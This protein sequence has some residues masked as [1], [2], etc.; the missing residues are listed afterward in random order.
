M[1]LD[2]LA[3]ALRALAVQRYPS[4]ACALI[5]AGRIFPVQNAAEDATEEFVIPRMAWLEVEAQARAPV[6]AVFHSHPGG[7]DY[8]SEAD[9]RMQVASGV[10]WV[11]CTVTPGGTCAPFVWG[12][13]PPPLLARG[14]RHGVTDC[15]SLIRDWYRIERQVA[16]PEFPRAWEWWEAKDLYRDGFSE[17][18]FEL[19]E[20][21]P[22]VGDVFLARIRAPVPNHGGVYVG[23][24]LILHHPTQRGAAVDPSRLSRRE[25]L[26]RWRKYVTHWLRRR[27]C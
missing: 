4:E 12:G 25:P 3:P 27:S 24:G 6:E 10:P 14:F 5:A 22:Q 26:A 19:A 18:G 17:A 8:P 11:I 16:L 2:S 7:P 15:Y 21:E 1:N 20:G 13:E 9:M 23:G